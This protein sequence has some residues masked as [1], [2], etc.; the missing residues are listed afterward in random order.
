MPSFLP[1][2]FAQRQRDGYEFEFRGDDC[3]ESEPGW[4][5]CRAFVYVARPLKAPE[6]SGVVYALFS[7]DDKIRVRG[8]GKIPTKD[9][10][11]L[12]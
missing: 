7:A 11:T 4:P 1:A 3:E 10:P 9:D 12:F 5:E 8:D 2:S 6:N